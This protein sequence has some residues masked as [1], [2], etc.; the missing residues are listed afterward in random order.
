MAKIYWL[1]GN[2]LSD[3]EVIGKKL[4]EFLETEKRNWRSKVFYLDSGS[5]RN[6]TSNTDYTDIGISK[7]VTDSQLISEFICKSGCDVVVSVYDPFLEQREIF[8][9][10]MSSHL[11]E[12]Y[13]HSTKTSSEDFK[14]EYQPPTLNFFDVNITKENTTQ[15]FNKII[16]YINKK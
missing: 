15:T 2:P 12:F 4:T 13:I 16:H 7:V 11:E 10:K 1:T 6:I 3:K 5:V 9:E 14:V 8:K